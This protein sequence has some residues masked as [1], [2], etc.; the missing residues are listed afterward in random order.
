[1]L[2]NLALLALIALAGWRAR[3][4]WLE[5][6][7]HEAAVL[8]APQKPL[9]PPPFAALPTAE[10]LAAMAYEEVAQKMLFTPDRN[11]TVV[12]EPA[13]PKPMP[14]LPVAYGVLNLGDGP[15]AILGEKAGR[16]HRAYRPSETIGEFKLLS[17]RGDELLFEWEGQ[18][19]A[20]RVDEL[21]PREAGGG[22][23]GDAS[24]PVAAAPPPPQ[25]LVQ[26]A[27]ERP[28]GPGE[29]VGGGIRTCQPGD[30]NPPGAVVEGFRKVV[31]KTP[32]GTVCRWEPV[33]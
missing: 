6:E 8:R 17:I 11:P 24:A 32:F 26:V 7:R 18:Q 29:S 4:A 5:A 19:I 21:R 14:P 12:V 27:A 10:P 3:R 13:K 28:L 9:P 16:P 33:P 30:S 22:S 23:G 15:L 2:L 25:T 31:S 1:M 20:K